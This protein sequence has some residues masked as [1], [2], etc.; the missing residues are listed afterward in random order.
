[1]HKSSVGE[2]VDL[3]L[4]MYTLEAY[5]VN[6]SG[7]ENEPG[8]NIEGVKRL[9]RQHRLPPQHQVNTAGL[10][11]ANPQYYAEKRALERS[12]WRLL[13]RHLTRFE[14][15]GEGLCLRCD[16]VN[17]QPRRRYC[18]RCEEKTRETKT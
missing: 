16:Q 6:D 7:G 3:L 5:G 13:S 4:E 8:A 14:T 9:T 15:L 12:L 11:V 2:A 10:R 1:M 18:S 17:D